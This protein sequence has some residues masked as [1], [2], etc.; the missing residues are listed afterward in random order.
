MVIVYP[1]P[2]TTTAYYAIAAT[3]D[4]TC[5]L[6]CGRSHA[7]PPKRA[8]RLD[9]DDLAWLSAWIHDGA[10]EGA[11]KARHARAPAPAS[12]A[13]RPTPRPRSCLPRPTRA[14]PRLAA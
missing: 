2:P 4:C 6:Y 3:S 13:S 1:P 14:A 10:D 12:R 11:V 8:P 5:S 9:F 7:L